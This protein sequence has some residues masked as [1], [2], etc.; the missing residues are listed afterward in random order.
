MPMVSVII[1]TYNRADV[2]AR[3]I[4]SVLAQTFTDFELIVVD[5]GSSDRT[6]DVVRGFSDRVRLVRQENRGVSAARNT[7]IKISQGRL[8]AFLD[9]DD[10]WLPRKLEKQVA[11]FSDGHFICHTD[12]LWYRDG[13][14]VPQKEI[15]RKQGGWFFTRALERCLIS[16]SSVVLSRALL[17]EVGWFDEDLLAAEDYDLWLRVTAFYEVAFVPEPLVIKHGGCENQ[18][19][20]S[21][22]AIDVYRILAIQKILSM[23]E[24]PESYRQAA[25]RQLGRKCLIVAGGCEK[26]G[27]KEEAKLYRELA[28][29]YDYIAS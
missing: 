29:S 18:L 14:P 28:R 15:H 10:E 5:D 7:G 20:E 1:P 4:Q 16:P 13:K 2:L 6:A 17:D 25:C 21:T 23:Q 19:S 12:E 9:S 24:L 8:I 22:R 26:K 11:L 27:K 3:A